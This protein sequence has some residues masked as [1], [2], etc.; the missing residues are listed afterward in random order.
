MYVLCADAEKKL[1]LTDAEW[2][3]LETEGYHWEDLD[4]NGDIVAEDADEYAD[5]KRILNR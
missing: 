5:I 1:L 4:I 2:E 3:R